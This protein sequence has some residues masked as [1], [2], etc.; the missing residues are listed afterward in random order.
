MRDMKKHDSTSGR[1]ANGMIT[2]R[3]GSARVWPLPFLVF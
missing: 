1:V 2:L 3:F